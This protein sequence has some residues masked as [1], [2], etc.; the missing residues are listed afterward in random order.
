[1]RETQEY[2]DL[3][4]FSIRLGEDEE[5]RHRVTKRWYGKYIELNKSKKMRF[6]LLCD[7]NLSPSKSFNILE[8]KNNSML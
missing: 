1:M 5:M 3:F 2:Q 6:W 7:T 4:N 8:S